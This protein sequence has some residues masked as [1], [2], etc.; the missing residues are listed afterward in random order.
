MALMLTET[1]ISKMCC[2][3][4][5]IKRR[6]YNQ[7]SCADTGDYLLPSLHLVLYGFFLVERDNQ[8]TT[9]PLFYNLQSLSLRL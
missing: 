4:L 7:W 6:W 5:Y 1:N 3:I 2:V 9:G 8:L